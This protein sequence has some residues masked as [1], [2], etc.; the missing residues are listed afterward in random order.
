MLQLSQ[1][2]QIT[3]CS[4][5]IIIIIIIII[6]S[7]SSSS[8]S[9]SSNILH[10]ILGKSDLEYTSLVLIQVYL[11]KFCPSLLETV[12]FRVSVQYVRY[13]SLFNVC[14]SIKNC[15]FARC[16]SAA[17]VVCRDVDLFGG[18]SVSLNHVLKLLFL[19]C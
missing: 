17:N 12:Y 19:N 18:T 2:A 13:F 14:S 6:I 15:S 4:R 7:S 10:F 9:S 11:S 8:S 16:A 3:N 1:S 5:P